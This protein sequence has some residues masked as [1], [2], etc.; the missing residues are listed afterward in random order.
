M[1]TEEAAKLLKSCFI[2]QVEN[3][4]RIFEDNPETDAMI[5]E[6]A[7]ILTHPSHRFGIILSSPKF[8]NGKT[9]MLHAIRA[10][11]HHVYMHRHGAIEHIPRLETKISIVSAKDI[12]RSILKEEYTFREDDILMIDDLGHEPAEVIF[13]G[14]PYTPIIDLLE[15]RYNRMKFTIVSTNLPAEELGPRYTGR[16]EDRFEEMMHIIDVSGESHRII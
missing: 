13:Y 5:M 10:F 12:V 1:E 6:V 16:I 3:R 8:G 15:A 7:Y 11:I 9:T 2:W 4:H 14:M